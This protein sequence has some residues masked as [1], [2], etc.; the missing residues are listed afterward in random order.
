[1]CIKVSTSSWLLGCRKKLPQSGVILQLS[2]ADCLELSSGEML[3]AV[4]GSK[5]LEA[6]FFI[7]NILFSLVRPHF[8]YFYLVIFPVTNLTSEIKSAEIKD[9]HK[10]PLGKKSQ[11]FIAANNCT[12]YR[13]LRT[14]K[15][16]LTSAHPLSLP[17]LFFSPPQVPKTY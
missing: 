8:I 7:C 15:E 12:C 1:M 6:G 9:T 10:E 2:A 16:I 13:C 3:L 11:N 17:P 14:K 4:V 5:A